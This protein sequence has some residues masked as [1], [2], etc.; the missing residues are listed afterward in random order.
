L[1]TGFTPYNGF[2]AK[3]VLQRIDPRIGIG[4]CKI[5]HGRYWPL[6]S[7]MMVFILRNVCPSRSFYR[8]SLRFV[9]IESEILINGYNPPLIPSVSLVCAMSL[10]N[11]LG[12]ESEITHWALLL[13]NAR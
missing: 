11:C 8:T 7:N 3:S 9:Q 4:I 2:E 10:H 13:R 12:L 5:I 1:K 6:S